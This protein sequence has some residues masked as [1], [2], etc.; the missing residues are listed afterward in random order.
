VALVELPTAL[1]YFA[2]IAAVSASRSS[3][4]VEIGMLAL[5]NLAF[6]APVLGIAAL[7]GLSSGSAAPQVERVRDVLLRHV[8]ALLAGLLLVLALA[9][10]LVGLVGLAR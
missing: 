7:S 6:L 2:V 9:L 4:P 1:P 3:V 5:F 10:A 8:G